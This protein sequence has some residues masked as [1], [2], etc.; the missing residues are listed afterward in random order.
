MAILHHNLREEDVADEGALF[1]LDKKE[2]AAALIDVEILLFR[3]IDY[4]RTSKFSQE[5][6]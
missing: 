4:N 1:E 2:R 6:S 3:P 5:N